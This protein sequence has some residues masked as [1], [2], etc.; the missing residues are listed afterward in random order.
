M[1]F[2]RNSVLY[3]YK[4]LYLRDKESLFLLAW[5]IHT[6]DRYTCEEEEDTRCD[7]VVDRNY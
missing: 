3:A 4:H 1:I 5:L 7:D 2:F 6:D